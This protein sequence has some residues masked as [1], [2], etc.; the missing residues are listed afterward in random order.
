MKFKQILTSIFFLLGLVAYT[1]QSISGIVTDESG[2]PLPGASIIIAG[3][4]DGTSTDFD[5]NFTISAEIGDTL[6]IG[7]VGYSNSEVLIDGS[8]ISVS[9]SPSGALDEVV[10][11]A[12]G[13]T[14]DKKSLGFAVQSVDSQKIV[15]SN[16]NNLVNALQGQ[17]SGVQIQGSAS[18]LGGSSRI[19]IRGSNSFLGNNQPLFVV[20]GVPMDN[21]NFSSLGQ[22]E[23]FGG[24]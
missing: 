12:L 8:S 22:Q 14:R 5:G 16:E 6:V 20:D 7:Y 3:S 17:I 24:N 23:G 4:S 9:L 21:S 18:T 13:L 10:V 19:T 15:D 1:Q 2:V 11:T